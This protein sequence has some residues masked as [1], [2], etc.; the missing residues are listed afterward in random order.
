M[1]ASYRLFAITLKTR[2]QVSPSLLRCVFTGADIA[3]MKHEAPDQRIKLL[4]S[5]KGEFAQG[6][7]EGNNGYQDY[8]AL[9]KET[10]PVMRTY[11]LRALRRDA[12]EMDVEF[13]LHGENGPASRW[14]THAIPGERLLVIAPDAAFGGDSGGYEWA[15]PDNLRQALLIADETALP[16]VMGILEQLAKSAHPP[17]VQAF[18]EVPHKEDIQEVSAFGFARVH[19]I[20]R[21]SERYGEALLNAVKAKV[22]VPPWAQCQTQSLASSSLLEDEIWERAE[23]KTPFYAWVAGESS[24]VKNLR[25]YLTGERSLDRACVNFMAYWSNK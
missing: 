18:I 20:A 19:W 15:P 24:T 11:T 3:Q 5:E 16:A 9:P 23:G 17:A 22:D 2:R 7:G 6:L 12:R 1:A 21:E 25:R 13:V 14:A 8:L 10:R 4:F